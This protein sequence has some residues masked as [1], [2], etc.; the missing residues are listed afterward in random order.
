MADAKK[1][2]QGSITIKRLRRG[3]TMS[4]W[5]KNLTGVALY[6]GVD[7]AGNVT[8]DWSSATDANRPQLQPQLEASGGLTPTIVEGS[9]KWYYINVEL[10]FDEDT[11]ACTTS[12]YE[13]KFKLSTDGTYTLTIIGNLASKINNANDTLRFECSAQVAG[14]E[15]QPM[16]GTVDIVISPI[17]ASSWQGVVGWDTNKITANTGVKLTL[18]LLFGTKSQDAFGYA[19]VKA[20]ETPT[21]ITS[22]VTNNQRL[23][24]ENAITADDVDG[25]TTF[26]VYF[27][28]EG[29]K[30]VA[31]FVDCDG[32]SVLD[33]SDEYKIEYRYVDDK[34][35]QI[36]DNQTVTVKPYIVALKGS[37]SSVIT[38]TT[39]S[40][41][42]M[43]YRLQDGGA[44]WKETR[45][46]PV[47]TENVTLST[48]DSDYK[49]DNDN[50]IMCD[51]EVCGSVLFTI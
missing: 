9:A 19:I 21:A 35:Q 28:P 43:V 4:L 44:T 27:Y 16:Q 37:D 20:G 22:A 42:H 11:G 32:F 50:T 48:A 6:Q 14:A 10:A 29:E 30:D 8:P 51:V 24:I 47:T 1:L 45:D 33:Q 41:S 31:N 17:G 36:D 2:T 3:Y 40:W 12:G 38:P 46:A 25:Q 7:S 13:N 5:F 15:E 26:L 49:D 23:I 18:S 39:A 34:V